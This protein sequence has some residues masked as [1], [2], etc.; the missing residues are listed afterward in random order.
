MGRI[1]QFGLMEISR[2]RR[3]MGVLEGSTHVCSHC[4]GAG[5][6]RS[7]ESSALT[8]LREAEM[9]AVRNGPGS[10]TLTLCTGVGLYVLNEKREFLHRLFDEH[11]VHVTVVFDEALIP[12]EQEIERTGSRNL[13]DPRPAARVQAPAFAAEADAF[14]PEED[15]DEDGEEDAVG[16]DAGGDSGAAAEGAGVPAARRDR[17]EEG[18][19][20]GRRR[21]RRGG[22]DDDRIGAA[23]AAPPV[24]DAVSDEGDEDGPE[25]EGTAEDARL[26]GEGDDRHRRRRRGRRGGRRMREEDGG[27]ADPYGWREASGPAAVDGEPDAYAWSD[28]LVGRDE[29]SGR[30]ASPEGGREEA[31]T[32]GPAPGPQVAPAAGQDPYGWEDA[33]VA[34]ATAA[35][36]PLGALPAPSDDA[37]ARGGRGRRPRRRRGGRGGERSE[38][39]MADDSAVEPGPE[40]AMTEPESPDPADAQAEPTPEPARPLETAPTPGEPE[41]T[42]AT[43]PEVTP[44]FATDAEPA[45][46]AQDEPVAAS[47]PESTAEAAPDPNEITAPPAAP[48]RGWWSRLRGG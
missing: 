37:D 38:A 4:Q 32:T 11:G 14:G 13:A 48:R 35:E 25:V 31:A 23:D 21:R 8:A 26:D 15:E 17:D 44:A 5:R 43:E 30:P 42:T 2:Q 41:T 6:V 29:R 9:E 34:A 39:A 18:R 22:R 20:R 1:S 12:G 24:E 19:G 7:V 3:R 46:K 27:A 47:A 10:V 45:A 33:D 16:V 36:H 28:P 40:P